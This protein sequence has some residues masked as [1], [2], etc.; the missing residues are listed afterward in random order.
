[1]NLPVGED[2]TIRGWTADRGKL[3]GLRK[4][5]AYSELAE[6][7]DN[8]NDAEGDGGGGLNSKLETVES[9]AETITAKIGDLPIPVCALASCRTQP[10]VGVGLC[11]G[12][13]HIMF[14]K[15]VNNAGDQRGQYLF[16]PT[17]INVRQRLVH[18][19]MRDGGEAIIDV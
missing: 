18:P 7:I 4:F 12:A 10:L 2:G 9:S 8:T 13:V 19:G 15:Q 14:V 1:M 5:T 3:C 16:C 6:E 11:H 17:E